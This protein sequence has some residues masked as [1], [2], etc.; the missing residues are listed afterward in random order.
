VQVLK[1]LELLLRCKQVDAGAMP[2]HQLCSLIVRVVRASPS[3]AHVSYALRLLRLL[4]PAPE[5]PL[6]LLRHGVPGALRDLMSKQ[7]TGQLRSFSAA[8]RARDLS[9]V[10]TETSAAV[11]EALPLTCLVCCRL[12][13]LRVQKAVG[14]APRGLTLKPELKMQ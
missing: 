11:A 2:I 14:P 1:T 6:L 5:V 7:D 4:L 8:S 13:T 3:T 10:I 9:T 12:W